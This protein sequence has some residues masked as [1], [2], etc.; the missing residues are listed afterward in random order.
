MITKRDREKSEERLTVTRTRFTVS[1]ANVD[2]S[3]FLIEIKPL[4]SNRV[5][6]SAC[7]ADGQR[8]RQIFVIEINEG[9]KITNNLV[10]SFD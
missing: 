9:G 1:S 4:G 5:S 3:I 7:S 2:R 10:S 6:I 8:Q